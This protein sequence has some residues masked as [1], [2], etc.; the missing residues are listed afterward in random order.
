MCRLLILSTLRKKYFKEVFGTVSSYICL[1]G[2]DRDLDLN[3]DKRKDKYRAVVLLLGCTTQPSTNFFGKYNRHFLPTGRFV[4]PL[5][6]TS[7]S[8]LFKQH[9]AYF[10]AFL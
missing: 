3:D 2:C 9:T 5:I 4:S 1:Y 7:I 6:L 10:K 8:A